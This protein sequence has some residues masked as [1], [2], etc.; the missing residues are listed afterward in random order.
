MQ[1]P[2]SQLKD[3]DSNISRDD[4]YKFVA[5]PGQDEEDVVGFLSTFTV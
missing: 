3:S 2:A 5:K 4:D 1:L